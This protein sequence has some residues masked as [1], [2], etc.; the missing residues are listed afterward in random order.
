MQ[1]IFSVTADESAVFG[2]GDVALDDAGAHETRGLVGL[3]RVFGKL[4]ARA[5]MAD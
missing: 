2:E 1:V 3:E 4:Q 5:T